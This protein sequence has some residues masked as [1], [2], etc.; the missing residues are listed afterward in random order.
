V[1]VAGDE[2]GLRVVY[3]EKGYDPAS[4]YRSGKAG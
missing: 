4:V 3:P 2:A 1:A